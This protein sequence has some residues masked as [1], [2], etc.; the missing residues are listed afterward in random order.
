MSH[1]SQRTSKPAYYIVDFRTLSDPP[2]LRQPTMKHGFG[3]PTLFFGLSKLVRSKLMQ[4]HHFLGSRPCTGLWNG[5]QG[6]I[7][8]LVGFGGQILK[9]L[10]FIQFLS[11]ISDI[12]SKVATQEAPKVM[13][14][15]HLTKMH[16]NVIYGQIYPGDNFF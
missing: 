1:L 6:H 13:F 4:N 5:P 8:H 9:M 12:L 10:Q 3:Q 15:V 16:R 2:R 14:T 7:A 11:N